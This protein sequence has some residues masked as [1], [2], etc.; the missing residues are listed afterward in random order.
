MNL[1][2]NERCPLCG[3]ETDSVLQLRFSEKMNLPT[4][5]EVRHCSSD[6]F[7]FVAGGRQQDY[8]EYYRSLAND[9]VHGELSGGSL[10]S[11]ISILQCSHLVGALG[12]FFGA[13]RRVFDFGCGEAS[14]LIELASEFAT[15]TFFGY[16]PGPAAQVG[17]AKASQ[18]DLKNIFISDLTQ[19]KQREPFDLILVS[20]V[21][22]HL[23]DF[24]LLHLLKSLLVD[25]GLLYVEVPNSLGYP[26]N[27]RKEFLYYFDRLHVNHFTPQA[28]ARLCSSHG[29]GYLRH[30]E[31]AFPY[32]DGGN[33]PALGMLLQKADSTDGFS[34]P[35]I[36][37]AA[38]KYIS[39]ERQR[40]RAIE[41]KLDAFEGVLVWGAGDNFYRSC[42]NEGPLSNIRN[43]VVLDRRAQRISI[44]GKENRTEEPQEG[45]KRYDWPVVI[46]VSEGRNAL[47]DQ[48]KQIDP[49]RPVFF[50]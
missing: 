42:E 26:I 31:Y 39:S 8:D 40:A 41:S 12:G 32:R 5:P 47:G 4:E 24:D 23:I 38:N 44:G 1:T 33:Y 2:R 21:I 35:S 46:T 28:L 6:N 49:L 10:R 20:H 27:Q 16:D 15:S 3:S 9:S 17:A 50:I 29:F 30:F 48:V 22:E 18:L 14:L 45:I 13:R 34:S 25:D 7:L 36:L 11:P 19:I 37:D 43:M